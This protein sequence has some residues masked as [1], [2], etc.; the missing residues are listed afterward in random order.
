MRY[1]RIPVLGATSLYRKLGYL[2]GVRIEFAHDWRRASV[3]ARREITVL[4][5]E[6]L[7]PVPLPA[8]SRGN[9]CLT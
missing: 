1:F 3:L 7:R 4:G 6:T 9:D 5:Y 8:W 2:F